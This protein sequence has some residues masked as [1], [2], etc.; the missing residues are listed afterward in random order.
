MQQQI[1]TIKNMYRENVSKGKALSLQALKMLLED[2]EYSEQEWLELKSWYENI[3]DF[4]YLNFDSP[5]EEIIIHHP[6][7]ICYCGSRPATEESPLSQKDFELS[8]LLLTIKYQCEWNFRKPFCSFLATF[9]E[10]KYRVTLIHHAT[11]PGQTSKVFIRSIAPTI[12][13]MDSFIRQDKCQLLTQFIHTKKNILLCGPTGSGKTS[14]LNTM[15][16]NISKKEHV[17]VIED[18]MEIQ[19]QHPFT[20]RMLATSQ[21]HK[22]MDDYLAYAMRM[23]PDRIIVGEIRSQEVVPYLL[24]LNTGHQGCLATVHANNATDALHRLALLYCVYG[25][26]Q[27]DYQLILKLVCN[28]IDTVIFMQDKKVIDICQIYGSENG[29][30]MFESLTQDQTKTFNHAI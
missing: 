17:V 12:Y 29:Q 23:S 15:A 7:N 10:K 9:K 13:P 28:N 16:S 8:L 19:L 3:N 18:T 26:G 14:L 5:F 20:S 21:Q 2:Y 22:S 30:V 11:L 24:A 25:R 1:E 4:S 27:L 6:Q